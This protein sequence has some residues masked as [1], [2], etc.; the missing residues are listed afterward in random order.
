MLSSFFYL[1]IG[2]CLSRHKMPSMADVLVK[3]LYR[4]KRWTNSMGQYNPISFCL[5]DAFTMGLTKLRPVLEMLQIYWY[6]SF[7]G[8]S[9]ELKDLIFKQLKKKLEGVTNNNDVKSLWTSRVKEILQNLLGWSISDFEFHQSIL[10]WHIATDLYYDSDLH[11]PSSSSSSSSSSSTYPE[12]IHN[13]CKL[14]SDFM[15]HLLISYPFMLPEGIGQIRF[16]ETCAEAIELFK[17]KRKEMLV[18][19][20]LR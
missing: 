3:R 2:C 10:L 5:K 15:L 6:T 4:K 14:L 19:S 16:R 8:V 1:Q 13:M 17:G 20:C 9:H 11:S 7:Q 18:R 12:L